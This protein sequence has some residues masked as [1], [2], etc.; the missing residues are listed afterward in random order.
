[1]RPDPR[2]A[3]PPLAVLGVKGNAGLPQRRWGDIR[4]TGVKELN[5]RATVRDLAIILLAA[6]A[7]PVARAAAQTQKPAAKKQPNL[8]YTTIDDPQFIPESEAKFVHKD[9]LVLGVTDGKVAKAYPAAILAQHGVVQ[10]RLA[11]GPIAV[12]W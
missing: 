8:P 11:D 10:D 9:D 7:I 12:T 3:G 4:K 1:L 5:V 2:L 6:T